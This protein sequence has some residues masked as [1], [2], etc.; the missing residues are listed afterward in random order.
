[1]AAMTDAAGDDLSSIV[2]RLGA[3]AG[4]SRLRDY[5]VLAEQLAECADAA[6]ERGDLQLI[7]PPPDRDEVLALYEAAW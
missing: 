7:P 4:P 5:G 3:R 1:M 2:G 6:L